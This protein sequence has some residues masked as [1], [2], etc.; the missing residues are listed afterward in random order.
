MKIEIQCA[1]VYF[2]VLSHQQK[3]AVEDDVAI[4]EPPSGFDIIA[5]RHPTTEMLPEKASL[6]DVRE[7]VK[8]RGLNA[9]KVP[10]KNVHIKQVRKSSMVNRELLAAEEERNNQLKIL[11]TALKK[12]NEIQTRRNDLLEQLL[13]R[14]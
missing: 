5:Q 8:K 7:A 2:H 9:K 3:E 14:E 11:R 6:N 10:T 12:H 4:I 13:N 1:S